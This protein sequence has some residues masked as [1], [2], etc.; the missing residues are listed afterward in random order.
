MFTTIKNILYCGLFEFNIGVECRETEAYEK[1][2]NGF[3]VFALQN[4]AVGN[5][6]LCP[7]RKCVNSFWRE[8]SEVREHVICDGFLKG[9]QTWTLHGESASSFVNDDEFVEQ[10][11]EDDDISEL[12]RDLA[13]GLDD[14]GGMEDS[15]S[16]IED[17]STIRKLAEDNSQELFPGCKNYSKL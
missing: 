14:G 9:Y 2:L 16:P 10:P 17:I 1:G 13:C 7:C 4:S 11:S 15:E 3:L 12:I 6:I 5:K 8:V